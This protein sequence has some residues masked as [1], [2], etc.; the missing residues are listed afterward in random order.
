MVPWGG[1]EPQATL[2][3]ITRLRQSKHLTMVRRIVHPSSFL[4]V[5]APSA[6]QSSLSLV[7]VRAFSRFLPLVELSFS[8]LSFYVIPRMTC[9]QEG[10]RQCGRNEPHTRA[11][12]GIVCSEQSRELLLKRALDGSIT[13]ILGEEDTANQVQGCQ[14]GTQPQTEKHIRLAS[15]RLGL[16]QLEDVHDFSDKLLFKRTFTTI[17]SLCH[18]IPI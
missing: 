16:Y 7:A 14:L 10:P 9:E 12:Q 5:G 2:T 13:P 18:A 4:S 15:Q 11:K 1:D 8:L 6:A 17:F 3:S